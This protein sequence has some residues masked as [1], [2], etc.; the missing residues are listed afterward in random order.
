MKVKCVILCL[1]IL[2]SN[3]PE[4]RGSLGVDVSQPTSSFS[5]MRS[6]G[7]V[8]AIVRGYLSYGAVDT[9]AV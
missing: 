2:H 6:N 4:V 3:I 5:C 8:F 7:I 1:L 9:A